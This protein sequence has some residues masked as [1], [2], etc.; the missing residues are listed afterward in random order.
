MKTKHSTLS[1]K[2]FLTAS[3]CDVSITP[4]D[5]TNVFFFLLTLLSSVTIVLYFTSHAL[6][7]WQCVFLLFVV[8]ALALKSNWRLLFEKSGV[9]LSFISPGY[10][11]EYDGKTYRLGN[12]SRMTF[13]GFWLSLEADIEGQKGHKIL[14][15][16]SQLDRTQKSC[17]A[18]FIKAS[19]VKHPNN[20][21]SQ[22]YEVKE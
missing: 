12:T 22:V 13:F 14:L 19:Q 1:C 17:L 20:A 16:A 11:V 10:S 21:S 8:A 5:Q 6:I 4:V 9:Q 3:R 15:C 2:S 7:L 18:L